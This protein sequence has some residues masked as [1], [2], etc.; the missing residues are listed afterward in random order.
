LV[1]AISGCAPETG[2]E[3]EVSDPVDTQD[4]GT[5]ELALQVRTL[6]YTQDNPGPTQVVLDVQVP[7]EARVELYMNDILQKGWDTGDAC[8][9]FPAFTL[10][11]D[12]LEQSISTMAETGGIKRFELTA[13]KGDTWKR[14]TFERTLSL[15]QCIANAD[16]YSDVVQPV[17]EAQ[18][19]NCHNAGNPA[20]NASANSTQFQSTISGAS[21][22]LYRAPSH[23]EAGHDPKPLQPYDADYRAIAE[24]VW[25]SRKPFVCS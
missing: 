4:S 10:C 2:G 5:V 19:G 25:R 1:L 15:G 17:L 18:C 24:L 9:V 11:E 3:S 22:R 12:E 16:F 23:Q 13:L 14:V 8:V 21:D 7:A 20:F 6:T